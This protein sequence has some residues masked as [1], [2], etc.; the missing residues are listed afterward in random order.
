M[1]YNSLVSD[2]NGSDIQR[3][4]KQIKF[5]QQEIDRLKREID[6]LSFC[7]GLTSDRFVA[8]GLGKLELNQYPNLAML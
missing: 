5:Q 8:L 7:A 1:D 2:N 6:K 3:L 4:E